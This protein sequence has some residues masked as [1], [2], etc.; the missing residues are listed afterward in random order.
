[1]KSQKRLLYNLYSSLCNKTPVCIL[2]LKPIHTGCI[3]CV[4]E[5][6]MTCGYHFVCVCVCVCVCVSAIFKRGLKYKKKNDKYH[7]FPSIVCPFCS[8]LWQIIHQVI[9]R[10]NMSVNSLRTLVLPKIYLLS[11]K[12]AYSVSPCRLV[13]AFVHIKIFSTYLAVRMQSHLIFF[14]PILAFPSR[15]SQVL[16]LDLSVPCLASIMLSSFFC[17]PGNLFRL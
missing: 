1:M 9:V 2:H 14:V 5:L 13:I 4:Q 6:H 12:V 10:R 11:F 17:I 7:F 15:A 16:S 8:L 3:L